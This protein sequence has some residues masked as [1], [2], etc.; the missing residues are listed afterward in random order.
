M[1]YPDECIRGIVSPEWLI[2]NDVASSAMYTFKVGDRKD[3]WTESSINW[4][5]DEKAVDL[6]LNLKNVDEE[7]RYKIGIAIL[8]F[9]VLDMIRKNRGFT[10]LF[11]YERAPTEGNSYHG[12]LLLLDEMNPQLKKLVRSELAFRSQIHRREDIINQCKNNPRWSVVVRRLIKRCLNFI[13]SSCKR[14]KRPLLTTREKR[15][16]EHDL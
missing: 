14:T 15:A 6:T 5:D 1:E 3:G 9:S 4:R 8:P 2:T 10:G 11:N 12:N 7:F 16:T 13:F